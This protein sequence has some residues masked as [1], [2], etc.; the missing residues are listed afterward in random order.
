MR[1]ARSA[2]NVKT[3]A[4]ARTHVIG[5][6]NPPLSAGTPCVLA[7]ASVDAGA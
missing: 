3:E 7:G 1:I 2:E 6:E 5:A 4:H